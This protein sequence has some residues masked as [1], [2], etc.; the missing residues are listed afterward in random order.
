MMM[1]RG[2]V[3][4]V[5][6][7]HPSNPPSHPELLKLLADEIVARN[8][9]VRGFLRELALTKV[10][11]QAIDAPA[12]NAG[13]FQ[14]SGRPGSQRKKLARSHSK[15][16]RKPHESEYL[17]AVKAWYKTE[18]SL[19]PLLAEQDKAM[20]KHAESAKKKE[21]AQKARDRRPVANRGQA[22]H[23]KGPGRGRSPGAQEV[24]KKLPK[25]K[26]LVDAAAIFHQACRGRRG[27]ACGPREGDV[28]KTAALKKAGDEV[29]A[30]AQAVLTARAKVSPVR[31]S[32]R[33]KEKIAL[34]A[35]RKMAETRVRCRAS[36]EALKLLE[37]FAHYRRFS[38][39][40]P[41]ATERRRPS[42]H[43][44]TPTKQPASS[45]PLCAEAQEERP[46]DAR[47][48]ARKLGRAQRSLAAIRR[49][50]QRDA[51]CRDRGRATA[52]PDD[53][54][55]SQAAQK[56]K[57]KSAELQKAGPAL[58]AASRCRCSIARQSRRTRQSRPEPALEGVPASESPAQRTLVRAAAAALAAEETRG[59]AA[60]VRAR[61]S[62]RLSSAPCA[63]TSSRRRSSSRSRPSRCAS[64]F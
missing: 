44:P 33:Q 53:P 5:D 61:R 16:R 8:F 12:G 43:S 37:A 1:G 32:V 27:R 56:I 60:K 10:Y 15:R 64:A 50:R 35:R 11:Q 58:Q 45:R 13:R 22:R 2:L 25:D 29:I 39:R 26:E 62:D 41:R 4:P 49:S 7:H 17:R 59:K 24:V 52:L 57:E 23:G 30:A 6:L 18:E 31:E 20:V 38:S 48:A 40:S 34:D 14:A 51:A 28:E 9:N 54:A 47:S 63:A 21:A 36:P 46:G 42:R 3:H 19:V 55:L